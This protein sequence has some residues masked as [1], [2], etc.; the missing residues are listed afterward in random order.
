MMEEEVHFVEEVV[1]V[2]DHLVAVVDLSVVLVLVLVDSVAIVA[3]VDAADLDH[4]Y[5]HLGAGS[6]LN[7]PNVVLAAVVAVPSSV[8]VHRR[9]QPCHYLDQ[10]CAC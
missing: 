7:R 10:S 4:H 2:G 3:K 1:A 6:S 9:R 8:V 5:H